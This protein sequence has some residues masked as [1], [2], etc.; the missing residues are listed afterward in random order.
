MPPTK[1]IVPI[2]VFKKK[3]KRK[4][5]AKIAMD[6]GTAYAEDAI[7]PRELKSGKGYPPWAR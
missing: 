3:N 5:K 1:D 4:R 6:N 7:A 2:G